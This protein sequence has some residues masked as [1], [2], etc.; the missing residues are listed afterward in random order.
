M[1]IFTG[2]RRGGHATTMSHRA[3]PMGACSPSKLGDTVLAHSANWGVNRERASADPSLLLL[4]LVLYILDL[5]ELDLA[6]QQRGNVRGKV[7]GQ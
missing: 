5:V 7:P 6:R 4:L 3:Y 2:A 1:L